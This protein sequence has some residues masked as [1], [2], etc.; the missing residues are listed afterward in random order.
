MS[1]Q[2][3]VDRA[4]VAGYV[5]IVTVP[6][7]ARNLKFEEVKPSE[8]MISVTDITNKTVLLNGK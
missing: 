3:V 7:G 8:N 4:A 6:A 2:S 5:P 1:R